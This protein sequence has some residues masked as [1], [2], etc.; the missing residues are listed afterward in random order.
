MSN[1]SEKITNYFYGLQISEKYIPY[2]SEIITKYF[3]RLHISE[4]YI[5]NY[6]Q[7]KTYFTNN[8]Y[9]GTGAAASSEAGTVWND[10]SLCG[11][12]YEFILLEI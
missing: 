12:K 5:S 7:K 3:Y 8:F 2:Y 4:K 1:C 10:S 6:I 11:P 9:G